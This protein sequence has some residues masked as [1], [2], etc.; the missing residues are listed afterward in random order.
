MIDCLEHV[1]GMG[2]KGLTKATFVKAKDN[3][4]YATHNYIM[5]ICKDMQVLWKVH[6]I[7]Q[8]LMK[9]EPDVVLTMS[10]AQISNHGRACTQAFSYPS[11]QLGALWPFVAFR[12]TCVRAIFLAC[13]GFAGF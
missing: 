12:V 11:H 5:M 7:I 2:L 9:Y 3:K 4:L 10:W 8:V 13:R 6:Q 1:F